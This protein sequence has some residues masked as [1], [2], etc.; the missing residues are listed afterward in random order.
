MG[1]P[2]AGDIKHLDG[3]EVYSTNTGVPHAIIFAGGLELSIDEIAPVF[4]KGANVNFA[5][6]ENDHETTIRTYGRGVE[7]ETLSYGTGAVASAYVAHRIGDAGDRA[8]VHTVRGSLRTSLAAN[9][10]AFM[11]GAAVRVC[12]GRIR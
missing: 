7:G 12:K 5:R 11:E 3:Y 8:V 9:G 1:T 2:A 6:V 4:Q 10:E